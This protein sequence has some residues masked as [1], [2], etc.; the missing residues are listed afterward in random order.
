VGELLSYVGQFGT[1]DLAGVVLVDATLGPEP[2]PHEAAQFFAFAGAIA[3]DR[4]AFIEQNQSHFFR[5]AP[6]PEY[7]QRLMADV[8]RVPTTTA[9][10]LLIGST[11]V[12]HRPAL[13][14][15]DKP[16]LY[17]ITPAFRQDAET[18]RSAV[19]AARVEIF[20]GAGH[21][22]FIDEPERF[23]RLLEEFARAVFA[24]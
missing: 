22:L 14:K 1:E 17:A 10:A 4:A 9:L 8:M 18:L 19:P 13:E 24:R 3:R 16:V 20:E 23:N 11:G 6:P 5:K 7:L 15:L 2:A 21:T 12:D